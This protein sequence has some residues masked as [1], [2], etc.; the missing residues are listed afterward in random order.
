MKYDVSFID[1]AT[2]ALHRRNEMEARI[3]IFVTKCD[4]AVKD[5]VKLKMQ[6]QNFVHQLNCEPSE[7][8]DRFL[9][10]MKTLDEYTYLITDFNLS[11]GKLDETF[12]IDYPVHDSSISQTALTPSPTFNIIDMLSEPTPSTSMTCPNMCPLDKP[13][14]TKVPKEEQSLIVFSSA[15]CSSESVPAKNETTGKK[16]KETQCEFADGVKKINLNEVS[17]TFQMELHNLPAQTILQTE[18]VYPAT[19]MNIDGASLWVIT[20]SAEEVCRIM[21]EVTDYYNK[22]HIEM[23]ME[24]VMSLTYCAY[25]DEETDCYYRSFFIRLTEEDEQYAE[26]FLVDTGEMRLCEEPR[27]YLQ[28]LLPTFCVRPPY[29]RCCHLAGVELISGE[30]KELKEKQEKFLS[31]YIGRQCSIEVDDNTSESLGVYVRLSENEILNEILIEHGFAC[32]TESK[33]PQKMTAV[34]HGTPELRKLDSELDLALCPEYED[35][36][37][38]VTGYSY[39]DEADICKHYKGGPNKSCFKGSRCTKKHIVKHPDGWTLD[40]VEVTGK[41]AALPLPAPGTWLRVLVTCVCHFDHLYVQFIEEEPDEE[42]PNFGVVLPPSNLKALVRDMNCPATRMA[43][44]P[45]TMAPAH[46]ELVAA[47]YPP[48]DQW[49]R[50]RVITTTRADQNVEV[51]YID[52]GNEVWVREDSVRMLEPRHALLPAQAVRCA[53]AGV[54]A[55]GHDS[56]QWA[57]AKQQLARMTQD[58]TLDAHVIARDYDEITVELFDEHGYSIAEQLAALDMVVLKDFVVLDDSNTLHKQVVP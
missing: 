19:I 17:S 31:Q 28:P 36:V 9:K 16:E 24:D 42:L 44:K 21:R 32:S 14:R 18:H 26:V 2:L 29:A 27:K 41:C 13:K 46:G 35:P 5:I 8:K 7:L 51:K 22:H 50:A 34:S 30:D 38:A 1:L 56:R 49:Y 4:Q 39:R 48:D 45:L 12:S 3:N 52:Y 43:Y 58:R 11:V 25:F 47:L 33:S 40:R 20:D 53:L 23:S 57:A 55:K 37:E 10:C 54:G 6:A 15:S